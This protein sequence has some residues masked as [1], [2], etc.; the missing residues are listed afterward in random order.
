MSVFTS[1]RE[2]LLW[3]YAF[4]VL[5][6]IIATLIWGGGLVPS[7]NQELQGA[8][9]FYTML[10]IGLT[11]ILHGFLTKPRKAEITIWIGLSAVYLMLYARLGF[12]E[13]SHLFEYS[14]LVIFIH[15]ALL[16][17]ASHGK[18]IAAPA[19]VAFLIAFSIGVLDEIIQIFLPDRVFDII[20]ILF[21]GFVALLAI[22]ASTA[23]RWV[24]KN[25]KGS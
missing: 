5:A 9:F 10:A 22:G 13:R 3:F 8:L 15:K 20:D 14:I 17:R 18:I 1:S 25:T 6:A 11:I 21:N 24:R 16:E 23:I 2:R 4:L 12:A 19:L 7:M